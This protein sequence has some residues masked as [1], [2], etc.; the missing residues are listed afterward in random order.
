MII[1]R[2]DRIENYAG[3][4]TN[5]A[6]AAQWL[7]EADLFGMEPGTVQIDGE[8]VYATL[9]DNRL[10]R[11][12]PVFEAHRVYAD[13]QLILSGRERFLLGWD[14]REGASDPGAD[15]YFFEAGEALPFTLGPNEFVIFQPGELHAPLN[16]DGA[17][18]VCRKLVVKVR[19]E[20]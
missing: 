7:K 9:S 12:K 11:E 14:G 5:F 6:T 18:S 17:P 1:D 13:I 4:G 15:L 16:P 8:R 19:A 10:E 2:L 3:L 20:S